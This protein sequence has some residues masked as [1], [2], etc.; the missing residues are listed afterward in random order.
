MSTTY[1]VYCDQCKDKAWAGQSAG[2]RRY[3]YRGKDS[4]I[5]SFLFAHQ[6]HPLRFL[7]D[8][9]LPEPPEPR[10]VDWKDFAP[11]AKP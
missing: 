4:E 8:F 3:I 5:E 1:H 6:G 10:D 2:D 9:Q 11:V 7:A